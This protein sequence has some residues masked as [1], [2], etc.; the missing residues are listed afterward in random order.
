MGRKVRVESNLR[1]ANVFEPPFE[2][3]F[4]E[5]ENTLQDILERLSTMFPHLKFMERGGMGDDLRDL[6]LNGESHLTFDE[7]LRREIN[8]GDTV[9]VE[10]YMDPLAGG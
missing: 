3:E 5:N 10:A 1:I 6:L 9:V 2:M 7:G 4:R 8:E